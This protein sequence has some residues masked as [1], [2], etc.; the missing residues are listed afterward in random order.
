MELSDRRTFKRIEWACLTI[1][2]MLGPVICNY[3]N[4]PRLDVS[5]DATGLHLKISFSK[6][7]DGIIFANGFKFDP[8]CSTLSDASSVDKFLTLPLMA[9][10]NN[11]EQAALPQVTNTIVIQHHRILATKYDQVEI[12][13][14][15]L[16]EQ[17][18]DLF[19][20]SRNS[21][22]Q[23]FG[24][25]APQQKP[26]LELDLKQGW[27]IPKYRGTDKEHTDFLV[28]ELRNKESHTIYVK[29]CI[30]HD[31]EILDENSS[32]Y[33]ITDQSKCSNE[34]SK[35]SS[36][37]TINESNDGLMAYAELLPARMKIKGKVHFTCEALLCK[38]SCMC[39]DVNKLQTFHSTK[40][41]SFGLRKRS[42]AS[43]GDNLVKQQETN[44]YL[45]TTIKVMAERLAK[46]RKLSEARK[47][48]ATLD[49]R[50]AIL[51]AVYTPSYAADL[52]FEVMTPTDMFVSD[53]VT[54]VMYNVE[55][56]IIEIYNSSA[57]ELDDSDFTE[58]GSTDGLLSMTDGM[59]TE[60]WTEE[61]KENFDLQ[62][63]TTESSTDLVSFINETA[64]S[65]DLDNVANSTIVY[66]FKEDDGNCIPRLRFTVIMV[67]F[68]FVILCLLLICCG[69][70][71]YIRKEK[72]RHL[73]DNFLLYS[74]Y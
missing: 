8:L 57:H 24:Y 48:N 40:V 68:S 16:P 52:K 26:R 71:F 72:K 38:D 56:H 49:K 58:T 73:I 10:G 17:I 47:N 65:I 61:L 13:T 67:V 74:F 4:S 69:M 27:Q 15:R 43:S 22:G 46:Y 50:I 5:C 9:C 55:P 66:S 30:A 42:L 11:I 6:P 3:D 1:L 19:W 25:D 51:G 53:P 21:F 63:S 14:C 45:K 33:Q 12:V 60:I 2:T 70:A 64:K 36:A 31:S 20:I 18:P 29:D 39:S 32:V 44:K 23:A 62:T 7:F 37:F 54:T 34:D 41:I 28:L 59:T 35:I